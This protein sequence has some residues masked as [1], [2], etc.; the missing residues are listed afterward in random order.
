MS[1]V[2]PIQIRRAAGEIVTVKPDSQSS[3]QI[4]L[5]G[6]NVATLSF[7]LN[8]MYNF[9]IGDY[10]DILGE[11]YYLSK[12]PVIVK[13]SKY[14]YQYA[15]SMENS[16]YFLKNAQYLFYDHSNV[17]TESDFALTG[18]ADD[19]INLLITNANRIGVKT[20]VKG[21][22][23]SSGYK[24]LTFSNEDCL[25]VLSRLATEFETE[26]YIEGD[27]IHLAKKN[28]ATSHTFMYGRNLGLYSITREL[29]DDTVITRLYVFGGTQNLPAD[30]PSS[31]LRLPG[32]YTNLAHS[33]LWTIESGNTTGDGLGSLSYINTCVMTFDYPTSPSVGSVEIQV[34]TK[35]GSTTTNWATTTGAIRFLIDKYLTNEARAVT[36]DATGNIL[37]ASPFFDIDGA[38]NAVPTDPIFMTDKALPFLEKNQEIYGVIEGTLI[39][40]DVYPTRTGR[41][42]SVD[43]TNFYKFKDTT[44]DFDI[45]AQLAPGLTPKVAFNSGQLAGYKFEISAFDNATKEFTI[46]KN[47][48]ETALDIPSSTIRPAIGDSY[49]LIDIIMPSSYVSAAELLLQAKA[50][51]YLAVK[52]LPAYKY[53]IECDPAYFRKKNIYLNAG[54][55]VRI[56]DNE[57]AVNKEIRIISVTRS[58]VDEFQY[59]VQLSD[60]IPTG[61]LQALQ[62]TTLSNSS[63]LANLNNQVNNN[64]LLNGTFI[65]TLKIKQGTINIE[66]IETAP[67]TTYMKKLWIDASGKVWKS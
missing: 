60:T 61:T 9:D 50:T 5:M 20:W 66:D 52:S 48:D 54:D 2:I 36:K 37:A 27:K 58:L 7:E 18:T 23:I 38:E 19:F 17:L 14:D 42:T 21:G 16:Q 67:D 53:V 35:G 57:L 56:I 51:D 33:I 40:D 3:I 55:V 11:R 15:L 26:F 43:G 30:Y 64:A 31:R 65:G 12:E 25:E 4:D 44:I 59:S 22:V 41:L 47:K 24:T 32:G 1:V 10:A 63:N 6:S 34:R 29:A 28:N 39:I 45:N 62:S 49:V 46:L 13:K 8:A